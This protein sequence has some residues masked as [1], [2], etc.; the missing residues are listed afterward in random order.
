MNEDIS[1]ELNYFCFRPSEDW[2]P[3]SVQEPGEVR[4][5]GRLS[6]SCT[7]T[8]LSPYQQ[9]KLVSKWCEALPTMT[10]VRH[11]WFPSRV[12]QNLFDAACRLPNLESLSIKWSAIKTLRALEGAR[13][14]RFLDIGSSTAIESIDSLRS[15]KSLLWL[16]LEGLTRINR[17]DP[18][19]DLVNLEGLSV[20]GSMWTTQ[21]VDTLAPL[22][23]LTN[24]RYL[25]IVNLRAN[26]RTLSPLFAL[27]NLE[28]FHSARWWNENE[29]EELRRLNLKLVT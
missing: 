11:L 7:Q 20:E 14:L 3:E 8:N 26:D 16:R 27:R 9:K 25:S 6:V 4:A 21:R 15:M 28:V 29:M 1:A 12:P 5:D 22:G 18:L 10:G 24:L 23:A 19:S 13:S 2:P 17:L